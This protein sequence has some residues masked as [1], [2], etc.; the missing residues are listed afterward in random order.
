LGRE[1]DAHSLAMYDLLHVVSRIREETDSQ[2][3]GS[4]ARALST[5]SE[6]YTGVSGECRLNMA[7]DRKVAVYDYWQVRGS[8]WQKIGQYT[9]WPDGPEFELNPGS[10][11]TPWETR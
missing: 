7:G 5:L 10:I 11:E 3:I 1:P 9:L 8:S 4:R 2:D 6:T